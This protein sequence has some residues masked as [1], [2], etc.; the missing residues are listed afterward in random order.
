VSQEN[1]DAL[2]E[3]VKAYNRH[4]LGAFLA[5]MHDDVVAYPRMAV[6]EGACRGHDG[7]RRWWA[8]AQAAFPD[9]A[10]GSSRYATSES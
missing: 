8:N 4:D 2:R 3:A 6:V 1:I 7:I 9:F 10:T 5:L